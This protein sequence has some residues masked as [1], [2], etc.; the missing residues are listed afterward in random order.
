MNL[1]QD[2]DGEDLIRYGV[3]V[4]DQATITYSELLYNRGG[5]GGDWGV[6]WWDLTGDLPFPPGA[7]DGDLGIDTVTGDLW[8]YQP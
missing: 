1:E 5:V 8:R 3:T 7:V 2:L 4:P 6:F